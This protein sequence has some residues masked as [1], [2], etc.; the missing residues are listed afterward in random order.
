MNAERDE[1]DGNRGAANRGSRSNN[2]R[3]DGPDALRDAR[4]PVL[5]ALM[6]EHSTETPSPSLDAAILAAAAQAVADAP[7]GRKAAT[8]SWR[9]WLPLAA[10]AV[11]AI[12]AFGLGPLTPTLPTDTQDL[13]RDEAAPVSPNVAPA[14]NRNVAPAENRNVAPAENRN[15]A[16]AENRNVAPAENQKVAPDPLGRATIPSARD[17][18]ED[19]RE[20]M[21]PERVQDDSPLARNRPVPAPGALPD[22]PQSSAKIVAPFAAPPASNGQAGAAAS[23]AADRAAQ[24]LPRIESFSLPPS[25]RKNES[26]ADATGIDRDLHEWI[27]R[28]R[29][30]RDAGD[31]RDATREL[32]RFRDMYPEADA[33]LPDDLREWARSQR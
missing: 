27:E 7:H 32:A 21:P 16:P 9:L 4:D 18:R 33:R 17:D 24:S 30:L 20:T 12:V 15:V 26:A 31:V 1:H 25:S 5:E 28:I 19:R 10:A 6:R 14:E 2:G 23:D 3:S 13:L 29:A 8:A 11:V 22:S